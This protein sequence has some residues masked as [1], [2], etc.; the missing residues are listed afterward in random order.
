MKEDGKQQQQQQNV[1]FIGD[2]VS[3]ETIALYLL[4]V[5]SRRREKKNRNTLY[6]PVLV[7]KETNKN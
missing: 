5:I 7:L 2:K 4:F 1:L 6:T 3:A